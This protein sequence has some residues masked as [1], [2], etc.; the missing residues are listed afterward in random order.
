MPEA[1]G[2]TDRGLVRPV[3]Q[4][5]FLID[6]PLGLYLV[7]DGMGGAKAGERASALALETVAAHFRDADGEVRLDEAY[8]AA[9][10]EVRKQAAGDF[11]CA[12]MGTTLVGIHDSPDG[13][14]LAS[15]GDSRAY[16]WSGG[17]LEA[18][19]RDQSWVEEVGRRIG[20][21]EDVLR[22]HPFRHVI[23]MAIGVDTALEVRVKRLQ[24]APG[25]RL[26]LCSDGLHGCVAE[27]SIAGILKS[28]RSL[29]SCAHQLVEASKQAGAPDNV[30]VVL[31]DF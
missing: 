24:P 21:A 16:L 13:V 1:F 22:K 28:E 3:N 18:L 14:D 30:T 7:A 17:Q 26:L 19:T 2:L 20:L 8:R 11:R 15:A 25:S 27:E 23:T 31:V 10:E 6:P 4:D 29:E 5:A 9:H 12:G